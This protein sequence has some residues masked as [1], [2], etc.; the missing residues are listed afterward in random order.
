MDPHKNR[1]GNCESCLKM[2]FLVQIPEKREN[3]NSNAK[4]FK[5]A[6]KNAS[7]SGK[8][9]LAGAKH[10]WECEK[11]YRPHRNPYV[12]TTTSTT[13]STLCTC[14]SRSYMYRYMYIGGFSFNRTTPLRT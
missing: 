11:L 7:I 6:K 4:S 2:R 13:C 8:G 12:T 14:M 1:I 3:A 10:M 9:L 5:N